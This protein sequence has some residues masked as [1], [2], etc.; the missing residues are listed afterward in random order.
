M[1]FLIGVGLGVVLGLVAINVSPRVM[2]KCVKL[3]SKQ[4][5]SP[6]VVATPSVVARA[7]DV[8]GPTHELVI[9]AREIVTRMGELEPALDDLGVG[10]HAFAEHHNKM[11]DR[12]VFYPHEWRSLAAKG[13]SRV[14]G[15]HG[16]EDIS[17]QQKADWKIL[18]DRYAEISKAREGLLKW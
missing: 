1:L 17:E 10:V 7:I 5:S 2:K 18:M 12:R 11:M 8:A 14:C 9:E 4:S 15:A 16:H 3:L 13:S 6:A